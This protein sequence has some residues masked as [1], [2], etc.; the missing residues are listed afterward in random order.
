[1]LY[2]LFLSFYVYF[3]CSSFTL[4]SAIPSRQRKDI[5]FLTSDEKEQYVNAVHLLKLEPSP[6]HEDMSFY[7]S[8][9]LLHQEAVKYEQTELPDYNI[10]HGTSVFPPFHRK[11]LSLYEDKLNEITGRNDIAIPFWDWT[12]PESTEALLADDFMGRGD[13]EQ[14]YKVTTGRFN[15]ASGWTVDVK[16]YNEEHMCPWTYLARGTGDVSATILEVIMATKQ[17]LDPLMAVS[18]Y[19]CEPWD[20]MASLNCSFRNMLEGY[21][22]QDHIKQRMHNA[23]HWWVGGKFYCEDDKSQGTVGTLDI[24]PA[25]PL[26]FSL[27]AFVDFLWAAWQRRHNHMGEYFPTG[28]EGHRGP[29][30]LNLDDE[31]YPYLNYKDNLEMMKRGI[32]P[33]DMLFVY[34]LDY[35]YSTLERRVDFDSL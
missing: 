1:M 30:G 32:T 19:D 16:S 5:K 14:C 29:A 10:A 9:V 31:L 28:T 11:L 27:H 7:D 33:R 25:D 12:D 3:I 22:P 24:S 20:D 2:S 21:D 35:T 18:R 17:D 13:P 6:F 15:E 8:L 4:T 26:F 34:N 23:A